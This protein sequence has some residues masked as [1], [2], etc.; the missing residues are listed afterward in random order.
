MPCAPPPVN[1]GAN[2]FDHPLVAASYDIVDGPRDDLDLYRAIIDELGA[3]SVLDVG[4]GTGELAISL[5]RAG[6]TVVG[7]DPAAAML[8]VARAKPGADAVTWVHGDVGELPEMAVDVAVMTGNVAQVFVTDADWLATLDGIHAVLRPGGRLV[9]ESRIPQRRAWEDWAAQTE[10][11]R[12][13][14]P[15]VG[16]VVETFELTF[17]AEPLVT[18]RSHMHLPDGSV[19]TAESTLIFRPLAELE[20][21]L[22]AAG[23]VVDEI[24][25]AADRPGRE[26]VV[27][28]RKGSGPGRKR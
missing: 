2:E 19:H 12:Y 16:D 10:P 21:T 1:D 9:F 13:A 24:R 3:G 7:V 14:L 8:D 28:A 26:W 18:F 11:V 27:L 17:V 5:A 25:D 23:F 15:G 6:L 4:C 22:G 20:R